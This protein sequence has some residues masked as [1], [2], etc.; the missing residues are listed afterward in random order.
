MTDL[1]LAIDEGTTS[2]RAMAF[3]ARGREVAMKQI[4]LETATPK[5]GHVEQDPESIWRAVTDAAGAVA[6]QVGPE[7]I[8]AIGITNQ[9]ETVVFWDAAT[10]EALGPAIVWQDRRGAE[11]CARLRQA[12]LEPDIQAR[13]GLLLDPYFSATKIAWAL[14]HRPQVRDAAEAGRL[15]LGT[16]DS[17]LVHRLTDG[18]AHVTDASNASRTLLM[19]LRGGW[20]AGLLYTFGV[21]A[22]ALP[23]ITDSSGR[24][25]ET[26]R[27]G[28][29]I[30][31]AAII[32]DQQA[33]F[34]GHGCTQAG[35]AKATYGTGAF[36]LAHAGDAIPVSR[37][38][39]LTT[40]AHR[41][42]GRTSYALEGSVF[43]AGDSVR[44]LKETLPLFAPDADFG[45]LA[46]SVPDSG[47][48]HYVPAMVGLGAP[49]WRPDARGAL[50]GLSSATRP[51]HIARAA[52][53]AM[54]QATA[55]LADAFAADGVPI[56]ELRIGGGLSRMDWLA[57]AIAD[58]LGVP[59]ERP[60]EVECTAL[61]AAM[62]AGL[63]VGM[64]GSLEEAGRMRR[65]DRRFEPV[66]DTGA[67]AAERAAWARAVRQVLAD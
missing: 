8:A 2:A 29:P 66:D 49:H 38:R 3:D 15:R 59:T 58:T 9:R 27:F 63:G 34:V 67:R 14:E 45:A 28:P 48:V 17:W 19:D 26:R 43:M 41:I 56:R 20:D 42:A 47:G 54:A 50:L 30:P 4:P 37:H 21:P 64:F 16:V 40:V 23:T 35:Q 44:Y 7:R 22:D 62:L 6:A 12:G 36:L 65:V 31:I 24:L 53:E 57:Q 1:I 32:G 33:A 10:G 13:T 52:L 60:A 25:A 11:Q 46:A 55:D 51:G 61:G 5:P 18:A 39:L